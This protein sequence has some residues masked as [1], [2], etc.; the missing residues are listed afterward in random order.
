MCSINS[1]SGIF[2]TSMKCSDQEMFALAHWRHRVLPGRLP[3]IEPVL[4]M[5]SYSVIDEVRIAISIHNQHE[6]SHQRFH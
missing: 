6:R 5:L 4:A 2:H 3:Q 1:L